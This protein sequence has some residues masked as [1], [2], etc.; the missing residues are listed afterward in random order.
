MLTS[1]RSGRFGHELRMA[2]LLERNEPEDC[3]HPSSQLV[4][5]H[6]WTLE[7]TSSIVRPT[8]KRP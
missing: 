5:F 7:L 6:R 8:V 1:R 3:L 2:A 4:V